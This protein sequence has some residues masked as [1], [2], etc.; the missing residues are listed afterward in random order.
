[1]GDPSCS[2]DPGLVVWVLR[3]WQSP[4]TTPDC[5]Y[6]GTALRASP[7]PRSSP[8]RTWAAAGL[9]LVRRESIHRIK[10]TDLFHINLQVL[11]MHY[12]WRP[13]SLP[14]ALKLSEIISLWCLVD[15]SSFCFLLMSLLLRCSHFPSSCL[16]CFYFSY[17]RPTF[18]RM[19]REGAR[20]CCKSDMAYRCSKAV[21]V[22]N[23]VRVYPSER[24]RL[25][26][27]NKTYT[28]MLVFCRYCC[29][30]K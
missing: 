26:P 22:T 14:I 25:L 6:P 1:M 18:P 15:F 8:P 29:C 9:W 24:A 12:A 10:R 3:R 21:N 16:F 5:L 27:Q 20:T 4:G 13:K 28:E 30:S 7:P 23:S 11:K 2:G 17:W 19:P